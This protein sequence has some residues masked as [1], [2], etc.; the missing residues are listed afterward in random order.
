MW[1]L[2]GSPEARRTQPLVS[3]WSTLRQPQPEQAAN[4]TKKRTKPRRTVKVADSSLDD[5]SDSRKDLEEDVSKYMS[6][7]LSNEW[8][9]AFAH[10][11]LKQ[12]GTSNDFV[13]QA[14]CKKYEDE[15]LSP[16]ADEPVVEPSA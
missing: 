12:L 3:G 15:Y 8:G 4:A 10:A 6:M 9:T 1:A 2:R 16:L 5:R 7:T 14:L 11:W 13:N